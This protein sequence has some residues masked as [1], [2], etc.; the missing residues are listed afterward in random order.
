MC[1]E[2]LWI[3]FSVYVN[4]GCWFMSINFLLLLCDLYVD[5]LNYE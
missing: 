4:F 2:D 5:Y 3:N 1:V